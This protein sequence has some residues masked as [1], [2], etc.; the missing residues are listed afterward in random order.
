MS[1]LKKKA[2][3]DDDDEL[4]EKSE[5][6]VDAKGFKTRVEYKFNDRKQ[7]VKVTSKVRVIQ[8]TVRTPV[9]ALERR[10]RMAKFGNAVGVTDE[11][12]IT[13][14]DKNE[15]RMLAPK[16]SEAEDAAGGQSEATSK[17][18][19]VFQKKQQWRA[20]QRKYDM[21]E[22]GEDGEAEG[23]AG[24][25]GKHFPGGTGG[26]AGLSGMGGAGGKYVPPS[27]RGGAAGGMGGSLAT[28]EVQEEIKSVRVS[29]LSDATK[30]ADLQELMEPFGSIAR[31]FLAKDRETMQSRGYAFVTFNRRDDAERAMNALN[32]YG[33]DHLILKLEWAK[34][35]APKD[36][37]SE[38]MQF[39]SGYGK[40][41]AQDTTEK[42]SYAS[43]LTANR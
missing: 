33:Y 12:N 10:Q 19:E 34:P 22:D 29:N 4:P 27:A 14:T 1:G 5:S 26:L 16:D 32:G 41:L 13:I 28:M 35:A 8:E 9:T 23:G 40:A 36:P 7:K 18:F 39:R 25:G 42:V 31:I 17:A 24:N 2:W 37:G 38:P 43:N 3:G 6:A 21:E 30:E 15:V 20:L 11:S